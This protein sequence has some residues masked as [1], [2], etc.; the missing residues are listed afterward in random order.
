MAVTPERDLGPVAM[1]SDDAGPAD[2]A[3]T[4]QVRQPAPEL[5]SLLDA[6]PDAVLI[7]DH[8][9]RVVALNR[10]VEVM[11]GTTAARLR[12][13]SVESL[14]P[15]A[16]REAHA[17]AR[18]S[19]VRAPSLRVLSARHGLRAL[20]PD[21][22][23]FHVEISLTPVVGSGGSLVMAVIHDAEARTA[24]E[25][26]LLRGTHRTEGALDAIRDPILT[27]D[28]EGRVDFLNQA[29]EDLTGLTRDA[30]RGRPLSEV[31]PAV[32]EGGADLLGASVTACLSRG[33]PG[34]SCEAELPAI[35]G[36]DPRSLDLSTTPIRNAEGAVSG[37]AVVARDVTHARLLAR[38]LSHQATHDALTG[39]VNR[40]EFERRLS[41]ALANAA[42]EQGEHAVCFL[43]L[44][45]FKR[46]NDVCGHLA[47]DELLRQLSDLMRDRMRSRD[48]LARVGGDEFALLLEHCRLP[49]ARRIADG[50]RR[51]ISDYRFTYGT[52]TYAV[53]ASIGIVP[54]R[55][56]AARP[57]D[58]LRAADA[59]CYL[60]KRLGGN[61]IQVS[62]LRRWAGAAAMPSDASSSRLVR[63][64][65]E[66]RLR[67]QVQPLL[68]LDGAGARPPRF[69]LLVRLD[70][71][72]GSVVA[73][74]GF[75][76]AARRQG[77]M[78]S[79][80]RWVI[81]EA[82]AR[83]SA[84]GR[85]H[86]GRELPSL[87]INLDDE[88]VTAGGVA[89]TVRAELE[90]TG[91]AARSFCF[92]LNESV[93]A[94]HPGASVTLVQELRALGCETT[95]EHGGSGMAAFTLLR[96]LD[97]D[98][99]K[100]AG[101]IIRGLGREPLRR[102]LAAAVNEA[103][104]VLGLE[105]IAAQVESADILERVRAIGVDFAQGLAIAPP[106]PWDEA[107]ARL[108]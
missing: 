77:F 80:D 76:P 39:L 90:R 60:A 45:G 49:R 29:A 41:R 100:I 63:A 42:E 12:G 81:H 40:D 69:E 13:A 105:T 5:Q 79:L 56:G 84:W 54:I 26:A 58:V 37:V 35:A 32:S 24:A 65:E 4:D 31:L 2:P 44:D 87:A 72:Q 57:G 27:T 107:F 10:E 21:G 102:V 64:M 11:F 9:G 34:Q 16:M 48:T 103:G 50:L 52:E 59:A 43:D 70:E 3:G 14:L 82:A 67:L 98:Y 7:V 106:E 30:A 1:L 85:L 68:P 92:E 66:N 104:H 47:G 101:H 46:V 61:R 108:D 62:V 99:L 20:R 38:Q 83:L 15:V 93:V 19:Y 25:A 91:L 73:A 95:L 96:R 6:S 8:E 97:P 86:P 51:A 71:G 75:L 74:R 23:E 88:S 89:A 36:R 28:R 78:P 94:A 17:A 33:T 22:T 18:A 55:S 53:G